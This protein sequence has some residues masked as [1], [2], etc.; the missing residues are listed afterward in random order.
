MKIGNIMETSWEEMIS[1]P[2]PLPIL[3]LVHKKRIGMKNAI[4][5]ITL[6][7]VQET[8]LK[9]ELMREIRPKIRAGFALA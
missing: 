3:N 9:I 1:A 6:N 2:A 8:V 7:Y 5:A 4:S